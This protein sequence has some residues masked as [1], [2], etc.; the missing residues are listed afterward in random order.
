VQPRD[1]S[2]REIFGCSYVTSL[3]IFLMRKLRV[4][5]TDITQAMVINSRLNQLWSMGGG[6]GN[7]FVSWCFGQPAAL[8]PRP[9]RPPRPIPL[10]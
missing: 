5:I 8:E 10:D 7:I 3:L 1:T 2:K 9:P 6:C 4:G